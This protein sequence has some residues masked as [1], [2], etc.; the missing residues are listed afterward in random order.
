MRRSENSLRTE[1]FI[2]VSVVEKIN[3]ELILTPKS[4]RFLKMNALSLGF[5]NS[6]ARGASLHLPK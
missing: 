3:L 5:I 1:N 4:V 2:S 6:D